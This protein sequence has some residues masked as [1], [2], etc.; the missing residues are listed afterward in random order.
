[1][2]I[3]KL[4]CDH[5]GR[6]ISSEEDYTCLEVI[7]KRNDPL[8]I[9]FPKQKDLCIYCTQRFNEWLGGGKDES[10]G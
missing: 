8:L 2:R 10:E 1:M 4:I 6:E 3:H 9:S 5:C 7:N